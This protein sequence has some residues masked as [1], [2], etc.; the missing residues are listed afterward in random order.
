[1]TE[2]PDGENDSAARRFRLSV[3]S[4]LIAGKKCSAHRGGQISCVMHLHI[5]LGRRNRQY[6]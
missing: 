3:L 2:K 5:S 6:I 4:C 1:M